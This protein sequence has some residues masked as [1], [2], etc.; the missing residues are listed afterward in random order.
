MIDCVRGVVWVRQR[1]E[2]W[3]ASAAAGPGSG[4]VHGGLCQWIHYGRRVK[5]IRRSQRRHGSLLLG[6]YCNV[7]F[8]IFFVIGWLIDWLIWLIDFIDWFYWL[9]G[10]RRRPWIGTMLLGRPCPRRVC[11]PS[12]CCWS[13]AL[14]SLPFW[15]TSDPPLGCSTVAFLFEI[16]LWKARSFGT[17]LMG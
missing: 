12:S 7:K 14:T 11:V 1:L 6:Q 9:I 13:P 2:D 4:P 5:P 15:P 8:T 10:M 17:N 3:R 16:P